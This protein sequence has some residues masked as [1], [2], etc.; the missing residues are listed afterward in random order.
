MTIVG[1]VQQL[2]LNKKVGGLYFIQT[3]NGEESGIVVFEPRIKR[4]TGGVSFVHP[5]APFLFPA[6]HF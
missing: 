6:P 1:R 2:Q 4:S 5:D 3:A